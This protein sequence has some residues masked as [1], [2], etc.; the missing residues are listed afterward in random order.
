MVNSGVVAD[1]SPPR[2]LQLNCQAPWHTYSNDTGTIEAIAKVLRV[3][4]GTFL[5]ASNYFTLVKVQKLTTE[6]PHQAKLTFPR[7]QGLST[8]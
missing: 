5:K 4:E 1:M 6:I 2:H 7:R 3:M 8:A